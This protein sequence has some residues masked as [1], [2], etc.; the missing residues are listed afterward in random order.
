M[1]LSGQKVFFQK[2]TFYELL[3]INKAFLSKNLGFF[4]NGQILAFWPLAGWQKFLRPTE[5]QIRP[6]WP[7][8]A[9][10]GHTGLR[11]AAELRSFYFSSFAALYGSFYQKFQLAPV[12]L[13]F[14]LL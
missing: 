5:V 12:D 2:S 1:K 7:E 11:R 10:S 9:R 8:P 3:S 13:F 14:F 4:K 6:D